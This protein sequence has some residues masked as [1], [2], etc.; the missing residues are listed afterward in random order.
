MLRPVGI[1]QRNG[2]EAEILTG[3]AESESVVVH[4]SDDVIDGVEIVSR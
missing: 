3:L 4:P 2:L 1:G